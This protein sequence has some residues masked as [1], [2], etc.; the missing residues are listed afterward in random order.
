[1]TS[2]KWY[3]GT[4]AN[5]AALHLIIK[6]YFQENPDSPKIEGFSGKSDG[7]LFAVLVSCRS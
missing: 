6:A 5:S 7:S 2:K 3:I 1:M 4:A